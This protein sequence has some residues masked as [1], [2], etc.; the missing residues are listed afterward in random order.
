MKIVLCTPASLDMLSDLVEGE[1][2]PGYKFPMTANFARALWNAGHEVVIVTSTSDVDET[3][4]WTGDRF[5][6]VATPRRKRARD[7][8]C[9]LFRTEVHYMRDEIKNRKP[10]IAHGHWT[11]EFAEASIRS[12]FPNVVTIHD[13]APEIFLQFKNLYRFLRFLYSIPIILKCKHLTAVS[14][15]ISEK[16]SK[17]YKRN[18]ILVIPNSLFIKPPPTTKRKEQEQVAITIVSNNDPRKNNDLAIDAFYKIA[19]LNENIELFIFGGGFDRIKENL[20]SEISRQ[21]VDRIHIMGSRPLSEILIFHITRS[22]IF[23]HASLEESFGM[24]ILEAMACGVPVVAGENSGA[25]PWVVNHDE[26]G[27]LVDVTDS[28]SIAAS[29]ARLCE[30]DMLRKRLGNNAKLRHEKH[31]AEDTV[32]ARYLAL[33]KS[34]AAPQRQSISG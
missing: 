17:F 11:Y 8:C 29:L 27:L 18:N 10:D 22:D 4:T 34:I 3:T 21:I 14:P 7:L 16:I 23:L 20:P 9:N 25:V 33:Y 6:I 5:E 2:P 30:D 15:Y 12:G 28:D 1:P 19:T 32:T 13:F 31:F 26:G 24:S